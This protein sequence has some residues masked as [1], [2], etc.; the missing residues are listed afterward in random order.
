MQENLE[1]WYGLKFSV[2]LRKT[3][4]ESKDISLQ[5]YGDSL[6]SYECANILPLVQI[7]FK[8]RV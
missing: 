2:K 4:K 7:C 1:Q 5:A 6:T 3:A 8:M